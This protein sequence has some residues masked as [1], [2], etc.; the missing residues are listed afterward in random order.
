MSLPWEKNFTPPAVDENLLK[1]ITGAVEG[2][3]QTG[4]E[5][6]TSIG[7]AAAGQIAGQQAAQAVK[8]IGGVATAV[9]QGVEGVASA[10]VP[11]IAPPP[12]GVSS[13]SV[14]VTPTGTTSTPNGGDWVAAIE[15]A[16]MAT[17]GDALKSVLP[18]VQDRIA[19]EAEKV[20]AEELS[21][22][23]GGTTSPP[24]ASIPKSDLKKLDAWERAAR[25][26]LS[27]IVVTIL[28]A[29]VQVIGSLATDGTS[30]DFFHKD[31]WVTVGS[32]AVAAVVTSVSTYV[33]R[34]IKEPAGA[35]IDSS[36]KSS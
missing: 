15:T 36:T 28:G 19:H 25:T 1:E 4:T 14:G 11:T 7:S 6:A 26:F 31:G 24:I 18:V 10:V 29:I 21:K 3:V 35:A 30:V 34:Y 12:P 8:D 2:A 27:G 32:L 13:T 17:A 33:M 9:E 5:L 23:L 20:L 22:A 16:A